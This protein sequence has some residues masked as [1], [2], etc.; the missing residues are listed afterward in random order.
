LKSS[1]RKENCS[2]NEIFKVLIWNFLLAF[3]GSSEPLK[4]KLRYIQSYLKARVS[5]LFYNN[6]KFCYNLLSSFF[7]CSSSQGD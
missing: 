2:C 5:E 6:I 7:A 4:F 1:K 3:S